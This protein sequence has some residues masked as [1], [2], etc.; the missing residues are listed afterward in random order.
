MS[1]Q[2]SQYNFINVLYPLIPPIFALL[3]I[4]FS[5][6][7][8]QC[9][10]RQAINI[11]RAKNLPPEMSTFIS[12]IAKSAASLK[13]HVVTMASGFL[14]FLIALQKFQDPWRY[15]MAVIVG[16]MF[17]LIFRTWTWKIFSL[18]LDEISQVKV[19][20]KQNHSGSA[21]HDYTY[22]QMFTRMH[23][24][25]NI[26]LIVIILIGHYLSA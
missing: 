5:K 25:F 10:D 4:I 23:L 2:S 6:A 7:E 14:S 15:I 19:P 1:S 13:N 8:N 17:L 16:V 21:F 3:T 9:F 22:A 20:K 18:P 26:L 24:I 12:G 11:C